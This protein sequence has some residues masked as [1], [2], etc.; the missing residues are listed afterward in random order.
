MNGTHDFTLEVAA[1]EGKVKTVTAAPGAKALVASDNMLTTTGITV[2]EI[3]E[4]LQHL[5][6]R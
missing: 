2:T 6:S 4:P 1:V 3:V 5:T